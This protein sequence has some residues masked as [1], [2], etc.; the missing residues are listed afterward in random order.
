MY[1]HSSHLKSKPLIL[2]PPFPYNSVLFFPV[3]KAFQN[4]IKLF[5][6]F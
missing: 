2:N 6:D 5:L 1:T 3:G 4:L